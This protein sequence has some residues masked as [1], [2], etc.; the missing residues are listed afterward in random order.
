[1]PVATRVPVGNPASSLAPQAAAPLEG[2]AR[3][4]ESSTH[5]PWSADLAHNERRME[6]TGTVDYTNQFQKQEV[7]RSRTR[8]FTSLLQ[9]HFREQVEVF[10]DARHSPAH[11]IHVYKVSKSEEDFMLY[12]NGVKLV[13]SGSR[14]GRV[15]F[16]F[17]QYLGQIYAPTQ[18]PVL[19]IEAAWGPFDQLFW[20]YKGERVQIMDLV[21]Y[22]LTEFVRQ[23][24]R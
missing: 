23:S 17:N 14:A 1:M 6:R 15:I 5:M 21:R 8:E 22:F 13:V 20:S 10:N 12:R 11:Q 7:L 24:F 18:S 4:E 3:T 2:Q 19:E 16:A 9:K